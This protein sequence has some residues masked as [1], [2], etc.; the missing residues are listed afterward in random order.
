MISRFFFLIWFFLITIP[1]WA[2]IDLDQDLGSEQ[3][4]KPAKRT[5]FSFNTHLD[6]VAPTKISKGFNKGDEVHYAVAEVEAGMV[7]YYCPT[8]TEGARVA[9]GYSPTY[10][11]WGENFW[12]KQDHFNILSVTIAGFTKRI[13]DWFWRTQ[14]SINLDTEKW[15]APYTS[16]DLLLWGRYT[17]S[18]SIGLHF[19]FWAETGLHMDRVYPVI[20]FD[21]RISPAWKLSAVYPV[22]VSLDYALSQTWSLALAGRFFDSRFRAHEHA[23]K[24]LVRYTNVGVE[25]AIKYEN[26]TMSGNIHVGST[27]G[28]KYRVANR[29]N[30]HAENFYLDPAAYAGGEIDVKF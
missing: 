13:D 6:V 17:Y 16:Y 28:G 2:D 5:P 19:G 4:N 14:L 24:P 1:G 25:F 7:F 22:N 20:G 29:H 30:F 11:R 26:D 15:V 18:Q 12:F 9:I 27:V 8:Y 21:W 23:S 10:L 3:I